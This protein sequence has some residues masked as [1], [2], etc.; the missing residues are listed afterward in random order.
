MV[1]GIMKKWLMLILVTIAMTTI[2]TAATIKVAVLPLKRLDSASKYIQKFL[3][4]RDLEYT[5]NSQKTPKYELLN[6]KTT[7][8][9][10]KEAEIPDIDEMDKADL[11]ALSN[12]L[13]SDVL[14]RG[15]INAISSQQFA[16]DFRF[17][18][19]RTDEIKSIKSIVVKDKILRWAA[20]K[21][22]I[23]ETLDKFISDEAA[24]I[25]TMAMQ[26]F[27]SE[28]FVN[29]EQKFN[30]ILQY[31]PNDN[32][33]YKHLGLIAHKQKNYEKAITML[34]TS[35]NLVEKDTLD[36]AEVKK[37]NLASLLQNMVDVYK[38]S[39]NTEKM[40]KAQE[41]IAALDQDKEMWLTIANAYV[42]EKQT[43]KAKAALREALKIDKDYLNGIIRLS[44]LLYDDGSYTEA[45]PYLE[46][47]VEVSP[48]N[49]QVGK[50]LANAYQKTGRISESIAKYENLVAANPTNKLGYLKLAELYR[51]A[52]QDA[53]D[54]N[55]I[56]EYNKKAVE[57]LN[58]L[59]AVDPNDVT[60][61]VMLADVYLAT[62]RPAEAETS[63]NTAIS[64][65]SKLYQPYMILAAVN[66]RKGIDK[67]NQ[68]IDIEKLFQKAFGPTANRLDKERK[69]AKL[70]ANGFF[71]K[72]EGN[73]KDAKSKT[74]DPGN[75]NEINT[76]MAAIIQ[77]IGQTSN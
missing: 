46:R 30:A 69:A 67:Y 27:Q 59:K 43:S 77:Y 22:D 33:A 54:S 56:D 20:L 50:L 39:K 70:A 26:D 4:I 18:S 36:T 52:T 28:D 29:A 71:H 62:N 24:K 44:I 76:K 49:Q 53:S 73:L 14:I 35:Y 37:N 38:D 61:Y 3:T 45:I 19:A 5:F 75:I 6:L 65:D 9:T 60:L 51:A 21:K 72:A 11:A 8:V 17:Y 74:D 23:F 2:L 64:K 1:G 41:Q 12:E 16:V 63:A 42:A 47:V 55:K 40:M 10:F 66:Q 68:Y 34:T 32:V 48:D 7:A 15:T 13:K 57:T 58:R 25:S 31:N